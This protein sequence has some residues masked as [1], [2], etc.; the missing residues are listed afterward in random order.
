MDNSGYKIAVASSDGIVVNNHFG[1][2]RIFHIYH[3]DEDG[4][5]KYLEKREV[6]PVCEYGTHDEDRLIENL[7]KIEDCRYLL[8]SKIGDKAAAT[9]EGLGV[10]SYE[11]PGIIPESIKKLHQYVM[12]NKLFEQERK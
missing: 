8:V 7:K 9:A 3:L 5:I 6:T 11:I 4:T 1:R 12:I 10:E 2:A